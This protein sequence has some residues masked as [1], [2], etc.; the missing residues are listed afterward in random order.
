MTE[1]QPMEPADAFAEL[2]RMKL[3]EASLDG[4][5]AKIAEL[6]KRTV[7]GAA[8]VSVTVIRRLGP[9]TAACTGALARRLD[10]CQYTEG[11]GPCLDASHSGGRISVPA[12]TAERRWPRWAAR[13]R[14]EGVLSALSIA[15]PVDEGASGALNVYAV[16]PEAFDDEAVVLAEAFAGYAAVALADAH[17]YDVTAALARNMR[18]AMEHRAVVEQAKGIVMG[19]RRCGA[20]EAFRVLSRVAQESGRRLRDVAAALVAQAQLRPGQ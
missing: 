20:E 9:H 4:V 18:A 2:G 12:M 15:L 10:E 11:H 5:L 7:P 8:E 1:T 13:A 16:K 14:G 6:A 3:S 19:E 17:L